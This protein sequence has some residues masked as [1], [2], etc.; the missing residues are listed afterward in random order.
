MLTRPRHLSLA[1][2][3]AWDRAL[4]HV[5]AREGDPDALWE[6]IELYAR[7]VH[8]SGK[9]HEA[10]RQA[11]E[12]L[13]AGNPNGASGVHPLVKAI[14]DADRAVWR[15]GRSLGLTVPGNARRVGRP[16]SGEARTKG[17]TS[18][19]AARKR[20]RN[21]PRLSLVKAAKR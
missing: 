11:G 8:R 17:K 9:A 7:A 2:R 15:Y 19:P 5:E 12:P 4:A 18:R 1:G 6:Q 13:T 20:K 16:T 3:R 14:E 10:W 21:D